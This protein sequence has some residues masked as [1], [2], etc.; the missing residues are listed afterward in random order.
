M[1]VPNKSFETSNYN[2]GAWNNVRHFVICPLE[3]QS[4]FYHWVKPSSFA[5]NCCFIIRYIPSI[6]IFSTDID[7][8][9]ENNRPR[10]CHDNATCT[11]TNGS[12][13]CTCKNGYTGNG[14][15]C[16]G[17]C[18]CM[19]WSIFVLAN[20]FYLLLYFYL[21]A[22]CLFLIFHVFSTFSCI[23]SCLFI[24]CFDLSSFFLS[25]LHA[26]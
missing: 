2:S 4:F 17:Q 21:H 19:F 14:A 15:S 3:R 24:N 25:W 26:L 22:V 10:Y 1:H 23:L 18:I 20:L 6:Y 9:S 12:Y 8:C 11:N 7:E 16:Q 5:T 13:T